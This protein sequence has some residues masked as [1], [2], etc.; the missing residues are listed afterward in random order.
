MEF[1][2]W[3]NKY[4]RKYIYFKKNKVHTWLEYH[5]RSRKHW[6]YQIKVHEQGFYPVVYYSSESRNEIFKLFK[7]LYKQLTKKY[8]KSDWK[9]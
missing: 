5:P 6:S 3:Y 1:D 4:G 9:R 8:G 7:R 2:E